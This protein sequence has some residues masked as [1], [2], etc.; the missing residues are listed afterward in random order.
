M[1]SY[2]TKK[3]DK[4][5]KG[6]TL[7][8]SLATYSSSLPT[9]YVSSYYQKK[10]KAL[11]VLAFHPRDYDVVLSLVFADGCVFATVQPRE[12]VHVGQVHVRHAHDAV[13]KAQVPS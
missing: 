13:C 5:Q 9:T 3:N 4:K 7:A 1:S 6:A 2:S 11:D 12:K 10:K 8:A